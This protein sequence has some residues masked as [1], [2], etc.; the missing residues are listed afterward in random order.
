MAWQACM[1]SCRAPTEA[2]K[3]L[4]AVSETV[5]KLRAQ[6]DFLSEA[7]QKH[8]A[9][10]EQQLVARFGVTFPCRPVSDELVALKAHKEVLSRMEA[11]LKDLQ[12]VP[13]ESVGKLDAL[14]RESNQLAEVIK[15]S[16]IESLLAACAAEDE[17]AEKLLQ[18][19]RNVVDTVLR[20]ETFCIEAA[21]VFVG[22]GERGAACD[23]IGDCN[24]P[25]RCEKGKCAGKVSVS[26]VRKV[27]DGAKA[28]ADGGLQLKLHDSQGLDTRAQRQ[29]HDLEKDV[30]KA[31]AELLEHDWQNAVKQWRE[32]YRKELPAR[33]QELAG[34]L[35][36][37]RTAAEDETLAKACRR[38]HD[39][40][41]GR[42][43]DLDLLQGALGDPDPVS[44]AKW[45]RLKSRDAAALRAEIAELEA[46]VEERCTPAEEEGGGWVLYAIAGAAALLVLLIVGFVLWRR[47]RR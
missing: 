20:G 13:N 28:L 9:E 18:R 39:R 32:T 23:W 10:R 30:Q 22:E 11:A 24:M 8:S 47:K 36:E 42:A 3:R 12:L 27:L 2:E 46:K 35:E 15:A 37:H 45:V 1:P 34:A 43:K 26:E 14:E 31:E 7:L 38:A 29:L 33:L 41:A 5:G 40:V 21:H 6:A 17:L 44:R 16:A 25:L 4:W 19:K